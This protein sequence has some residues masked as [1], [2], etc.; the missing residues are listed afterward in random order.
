M[1]EAASSDP[2]VRAHLWMKAEGMQRGRDGSERSAP[3]ILPRRGSRL[4][5]MKAPMQPAP[6]DIDTLLSVE[7][8]GQVASQP[9]F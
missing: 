8:F 2:K 3:T 4:R 7:T 1:D 5:L 9:R 6:T